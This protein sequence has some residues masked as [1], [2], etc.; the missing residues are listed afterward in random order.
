ML[1]EKLA[2]LSAS[3]RNRMIIVSQVLLHKISEHFRSMSKF[4]T[5]VELHKATSEDYETLHAEMKK[6]GFSTFI[7]ETDTGKKYHLPT[8]EYNK[9]GPDTMTKEEVLASA[10]RAADKTKKKYS[11]L[12]TKS[13]G[14]TWSNLES[15]D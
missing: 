9:V 2:E 3:E 10:E 6:E 12:V 4:T 13:G 7:I 11:I 15:V 1:Y 14:R 8:A 5:R